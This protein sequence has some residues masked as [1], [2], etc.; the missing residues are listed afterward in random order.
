MLVGL[1]LLGC[2]DN[3]AEREPPQAVITAPAPTAVDFDAYAAGTVVEIRMAR[4]ALRSGKAI[5]WFAVDSA[6]AAAVGMPLERYRAMTAAV[7]TALKQPV[8]TVGEMR[9][10]D[11]LRVELMVLQVRAEGLP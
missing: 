7:E 11:S 2:R 5:R 10:L 6:G 4:R 1:G 9:R 3:E 8:A